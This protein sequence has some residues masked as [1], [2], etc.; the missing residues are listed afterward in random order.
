M[1]TDNFSVLGLT[2]DYGPFGFLDRF[3][4]GH[5]CN[6]SDHAGRYAWDQQPRV[7]HWN[8]A[9]F[10]QAL[11]PL[12]ADDEDAAVAVA[13]ELLEAFQPAYATA[14]LAAWRGKLGLTGEQAAD[15]ELVQ[16][17]LALLQT[18]GLDFSNS[19]RVFADHHGDDCPGAWVELTGMRDWWANYLT[20]RGPDGEES[21]TRAARHNPVYV[22]RNHLAQHVI[23]RAHDGD[24]GDIDTLMKRLAA[25]YT[26]I[27]GH[28]DFETPPPAGAACVAVSC[29]S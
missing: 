14:A 9:R 7:A 6:H 1:N 17:F 4:A 8:C 16:D 12:L 20:R 15:G 5:V 13:T 28:S 10:L 23:E 19:F 18:H 22:L 26:R 2:I 24:Y 3:D 29:S 25:P 27:D 21:R 11:L